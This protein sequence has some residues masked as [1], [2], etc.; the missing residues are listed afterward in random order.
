M[1]YK[2]LTLGFTLH[3]YHKLCDLLTYISSF[4]GHNCNYSLSMLLVKQRAVS[5][6]TLPSD[7]GEPD[8][9]L[10]KVPWL[11]IWSKPFQNSFHSIR[12]YIYIYSTYYIYIYLQCV[13][14]FLKIARFEWFRTIWGDYWSKNQVYLLCYFGTQSIYHIVNVKHVAVFKRW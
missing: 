8:R 12:V 4:A 11:W 5:R 13:V 7:T 10:G 6:G 9:G 2:G 14:L 1:F 3:K